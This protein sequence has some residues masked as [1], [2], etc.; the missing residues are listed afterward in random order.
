MADAALN[1]MAVAVLFDL[2]DAA[3]YFLDMLTDVKVM[4]VRPSSAHCKAEAVR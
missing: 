3:L 1:S 2:A 4:Q